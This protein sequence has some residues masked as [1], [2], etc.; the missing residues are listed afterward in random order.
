M[1]MPLRPLSGMILSGLLLTSL[2]SSATVAGVCDSVINQRAFNTSDKR[3]VAEAYSYARS[4]MCNES[5]SEQNSFRQAANSLGISGSYAEYAFG[6]N[7]S[8]SS[9]GGD[10]SAARSKFCG[11]SENEYKSYLA[12]SESTVDPTEALD[13]WT[14][15]IQL[16]SSGLWAQVDEG[17]NYDYV[18][19]TLIHRDNGDA[20]PYHLYSIN[21]QDD[22]SCREG[23]TPITTQRDIKGNTFTFRCDKPA[24]LATTMSL[25]TS[26]G[27]AV[28]INAVGTALSEAELRQ[29][30]QDVANLKAITAQTTTNV[31]EIKAFAPF[32]FTATG[33]SV[34]HELGVLFALH[35]SNVP[36]PTSM[37][38]LLS[39]SNAGGFVNHEWAQLHVCHW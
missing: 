37:G 20:Q 22:V 24:T 15:C 26:A 14:K 34:G 35:D 16:Q 23:D 1:T 21:K 11:M 38:F 2:T 39:G 12:S 6:L 19:I 30:Q 7:S 10:Y 32:S 5:W 4:A 17:P 27:N 13:A 8:N 18:D 9:S 3:S 31:A 28:A 29:L 36:N 33:C 25:N